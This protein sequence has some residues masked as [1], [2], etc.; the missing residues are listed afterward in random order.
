M[1]LCSN[2][3]KKHAE[4]YK[5]NLIEYEKAIDEKLKSIDN[6]TGLEMQKDKE[7]LIKHLKGGVLDE[8]FPDKTEKKRILNVLFGKYDSVFNGLEK[9]GRTTS[10]YRNK[11]K[12]YF[13]N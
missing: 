9:G 12:R 7:I 6:I 2:E 4:E 3:G 1:I 8:M 10:E 13:I 5:N 11:I